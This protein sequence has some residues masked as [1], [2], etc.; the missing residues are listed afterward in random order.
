[1][2]RFYLLFLLTPLLPAQPVF[3]DVFPPDEYA[4]RRA[5]VMAKIGDAVMNFSNPG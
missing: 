1:M 5:R 4:A 3:T 2:I